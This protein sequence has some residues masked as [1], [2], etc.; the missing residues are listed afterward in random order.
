MHRNFQYQP[1][2][3]NWRQAPNPGRPYI[4][5]SPP[6]PQRTWHQQ[7]NG[8]DPATWKVVRPHNNNLPNSIDKKSTSTKAWCN[9]HTFYKSNRQELAQL[10][11]SEHRGNIVDSAIGMIGNIRNPSSR[12][13]YDHAA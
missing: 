8:L 12:K 10:W 1:E 4:Q 6:K 11:S 13:P 7:S 2:W 5:P 3:Q 9:P